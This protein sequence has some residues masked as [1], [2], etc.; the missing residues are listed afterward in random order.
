VRVKHRVSLSQSGT[1]VR[2]QEAEFAAAFLPGIPGG[3]FNEQ[4]NRWVLPVSYQ[5]LLYTPRVL[6]LTLLL[7]LRY[8]PSKRT[9][10]PAADDACKDSSLQTSPCCLQQATCATAEGCMHQL[11][12]PAYSV[13]DDRTYASDDLSG[14]ASPPD[15]ATTLSSGAVCEGLQEAWKEPEPSLPL[16]HDTTHPTS[17]ITSL[18]TFL[19]TNMEEVVPST[20]VIP[21]DT[22]WAE[23]PA[24]ESSCLVQPAR[25]HSVSSLACPHVCS[26]ASTSHASIPAL[27]EISRGYQTEGEPGFKAT[28][29]W[30]A[31]VGARQ[32]LLLEVQRLKTAM[33]EQVQDPVVVLSNMLREYSADVLWSRHMRSAAAAAVALSQSPV[34][35]CWTEDTCNEGLHFQAIN[36]CE[37]DH[38]VPTIPYMNV[39]HAHGIMHAVDQVIATSAAAAGALIGPPTAAEVEP[40]KAPA[41]EQCDTWEQQ[42]MQCESSSICNVST[43]NVIPQIDDLESTAVQRVSATATP[44]RLPKNQNELSLHEVRMQSSYSC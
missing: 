14:P 23:G 25:L 44:V 42:R 22:A 26:R 2:V 38:E 13:R 11:M 24:A 36:S 19:A 33:H 17:H 4:Q 32:D 15:G 6:A 3:Q 9:T 1:A 12:G 8:H 5:N 34:L 28:N 27:I 21:F 16:Q 30:L 39:L 40:V 18:G 31:F 29:A 43:N 20:E 10:S 7:A 41:T 37:R 35:T